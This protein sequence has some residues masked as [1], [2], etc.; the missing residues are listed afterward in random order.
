MTILERSRSFPQGPFLGDV[1]ITHTNPAV[2]DVTYTENEIL[3][4]TLDIDDFIDTEFRKKIARGQ[5]VNHGCSIRG[6]IK[7]SHLGS[8]TVTDWSVPNYVQQTH[9]PG[10]LISLLLDHGPAVRRPVDGSYP[11]PAYNLVDLVTEAK[12]NAIAAIDPSGGA[13]AEDVGEFRQTFRFL[14]NPFKQLRDVSTDFRRSAKKRYRKTYARN[15]RGT[16][17]S[18]RRQKAIADTWLQ[19][20]FAVSPLMRTIADLYVELHTPKRTQFLRRTARGFANFSGEDADMNRPNPDGLRIFS[21]ETGSE[22]LVRAYILYEDSDFVQGWRQAYGFRNKDLFK[23]AWDLIP[24]SF[25]T[26]RILNIGTAISA[27]ANIS[28]ETISIR[29]AGYVVKQKHS[30]KVKF[31]TWNHP[32]A[33]VVLS[34]VARVID[35]ESYDRTLWSPTVFDTLPPVKLGNIV[36]DAK[37]IADLGAI[38]YANLH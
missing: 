20:R 19:Y 33:D 29:A 24:Y 5:I 3:S 6:V 15:S 27:F 23:T 2:E 17:T 35:E 37:Y 14:R 16:T 25:V 7:D 4:K 30:T 8:Q 18:F 21:I 31:H 10:S 38:I 12:A 26:D 13:Y 1:L 22:I 28:D 34:D 9:G 32:A 11:Y 36:K